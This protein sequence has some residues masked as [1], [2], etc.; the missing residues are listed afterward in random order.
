MS[1]SLLKVR[2][3]S[4]VAAGIVKTSIANFKSIGN[5]P[6]TNSQYRSGL[7]DSQSSVANA[8]CRFQ[9]S[10]LSSVRLASTYCTLCSINDCR[11]ADCDVNN[12]S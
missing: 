12:P 11:K 7:K 9:I 5:C 8:G 10:Y 6:A 1:L 4:A 3:Q 2:S